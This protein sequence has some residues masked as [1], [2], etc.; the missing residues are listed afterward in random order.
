[1]LKICGKKLFPACYTLA[2]VCKICEKV[3]YVQKFEKMC[4]RVFLSLV[5]KISERN[6][7]PYVKKNGFLRVTTFLY[8]DRIVKEDVR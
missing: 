6:M 7:H 3:I 4:S 2:L 1:M 5:S 8:F